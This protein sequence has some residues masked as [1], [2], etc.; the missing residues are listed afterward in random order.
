MASTV[1]DRIW[2]DTEPGEIEPTLAA[3]WRDVGRRSTVARAVMSNLVVV[4][5]SQ[6]GEPVDAYA[7]THIDTID[8]VVG[9]HPSRL[10]VIVHEYG[11]PLTRAPIATRV[12]VATYGPPHARYAVEEVLVRS[13][14]DEVSLPSIVRRL[15]RGDVP[16]TVWYLDDLS[17]RL[18]VRGIL[19]EAR[20]LIFD[21]QRWSDMATGVRVLVDATRDL[22]IDIADLNWRR[23]APVRDALRRMGEA[24]P[25]DALRQAQ[26]RIRC[27]PQE[28][29]AAWLLAGWLAARLSLPHDVARAI[30]LEEPAMTARLAIATNA[31][32]TPLVEL[33]GNDISVAPPHARAYVHAIPRE[34]QSD[35]I[36]NELGNLAG[37]AALLDTLRALAELTSAGSS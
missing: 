13:S 8:E 2:R 9:R 24:L 36:V 19:A 23:L 21:S 10:I 4:R 5:A 12:A 7:A 31:S 33:G 30:V 22:R 3:V 11:C 27:A 18:P 28:R 32:E 6:A 1:V 35:A 14:C 15:T 17:E 34:T 16:T 25:I 20:Q 37:D 29:A 26:V